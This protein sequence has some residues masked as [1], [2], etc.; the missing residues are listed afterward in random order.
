MT[1][2]ARD[3]ASKVV[4]ARLKYAAAHGHRLYKPSPAVSSK[5]HSSMRSDSRRSTSC[6]TK[7]EQ[8]QGLYRTG[9][10][11]PCAS[12]ILNRRAL[13]AAFIQFSKNLQ[14]AGID[15]AHQTS[16]ISKSPSAP[17]LAENQKPPMPSNLSPFMK[18]QIS[19]RQRR[20][21][22]RNSLHPVGS[23]CTLLNP[24]ALLQ[25]QAL[26]MDN[27][28]YNPY[29]SPPRSQQLSREHSG[30]GSGESLEIDVGAACQAHGS[31]TSMAMDL[32]LPNDC[33]VTLRVRDKTKRSDTAKRHIFVRQKQIDDEDAA[34]DRSRETHSCSPR[35][36]GYYPRCYD[37][38]KPYSRSTPHSRRESITSKVPTRANTEEHPRSRSNTNESLNINMA[39]TH[40]RYSRKNSADDRRRRGSNT[41]E[42]KHRDSAT[43]S[44]S[45]TYERQP[46]Q[47]HQ[48]ETQ[49]STCSAKSDKETATLLSV[50][51]AVLTDEKF[52]VVEEVILN[53]K[54]D[55]AEDCTLSEKT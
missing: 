9:P 21:C 51:T 24:H 19:P 16:P 44:R 46:H 23:G 41:S 6:Q 22:S 37:E 8:Q 15:K 45:S 3:S 34:S 55:S 2:E 10:G 1:F 32:H 14:Q 17:N 30:K 26:S 40:R 20:K 7:W 28:D 25:R 38:I 53:S 31:Q 33:P 39:A 4:P 43:L 50:E 13:T 29:F 12:E 54:P 49:S 42:T 27:P 18:P 52:T 11:S 47:A 5:L 35:L 36:P 48:L